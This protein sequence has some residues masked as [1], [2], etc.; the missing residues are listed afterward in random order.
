MKENIKYSHGLEV[1]S[2]IDFIDRKNKIIMLTPGYEPPVKSVFVDADVNGCI[3]LVSKKTVYFYET[4]G[5]K[6]RKP[7]KARDTL[8]HIGSYI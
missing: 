8:V 5:V 7:I 2:T 1:T 4:F 3:R 6:R